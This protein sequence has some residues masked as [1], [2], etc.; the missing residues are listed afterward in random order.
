MQNLTAPL[1]V[2][3]IGNKAIPENKVGIPMTSPEKVAVPPRCSAYA[4]ADETML[5]KDNC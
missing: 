3:V 5:K 4:L 2:L 1:S